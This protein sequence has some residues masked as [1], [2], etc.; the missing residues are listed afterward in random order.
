MAIRVISLPDGEEVVRATSTDRENLFLLDCDLPDGEYLIHVSADGEELQL[1][2]NSGRFVV[3]PPSV[4]MEVTYRDASLKVEYELDNL[5]YG[6]YSLALFDAHGNTVFKKALNP[7]DNQVEA[8]VDLLPQWKYT[9]NIYWNGEVIGDQPL[10]LGASTIDDPA[11]DDLVVSLPDSASGQDSLGT[12]LAYLIKQTPEEMTGETLFRL[13]TL[14]PQMLQQYSGEQLDGLWRPLARISDVNRSTFKPLPTWALMNNAL[15]MMT[16]E[17]T[18]YWVYPERIAW[19]GLAGIGKITL[20]T[21]QEGEITAYARWSMKRLFSSRLR[22]WI[23]AQDPASAAFSELD[24]LDM[25]PAYY[26]RAS[27]KFHG[28]RAKS[29][30][31]GLN[32]ANGTYL[33]DC[34]HEYTL[35]VRNRR[36]DRPLQHVYSSSDSIDRRYTQAI[37]RQGANGHL[38]SQYAQDITSAEGYRQATAEWYKQFAGDDA[39]RSQLRALADT[40]SV[41]GKLSTFIA[42]IPQILQKYDESLLSSG[43]RFI[44]GMEGQ[45]RTDSGDDMMRLDRHMLALGM[46]LRSYS[47]QRQPARLEILKRINMKENQLIAL[48]ESANRVCP[49]LLEWALTWSEIF[50]VHSSA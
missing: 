6:D 29:M 16:K 18:L 12:W 39:T 13:A 28:S 50:L 44:R 45:V 49:D 35:V 27:G 38:H 20:Q 31:P 32:K 48:L 10:L 33:V 11:A 19:R 30:M 7:D 47:L 34:A 23:P 14:Q 46:I 17:A 4:V 41:S 43:L 24:E 9:V 37:M 2:A 21:P 26:D 15:L 40:K 22:V 25:W 8:N 5:R 36:A 1:P 42:K 3:K